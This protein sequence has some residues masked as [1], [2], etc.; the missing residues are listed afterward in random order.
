MEGRGPGGGMVRRWIE[1]KW[2]LKCNIFCII[3]KDAAL[4]FRFSTV[5]VP[6]MRALTFP[7][8]YF[9]LLV[10]QTIQHFT[11]TCT[12]REQAFIDTCIDSHAHTGL[13]AKGTKLNTLIISSLHG[14]NH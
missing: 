10:C 12:H 2:Y 13:P 4:V 7:D 5:R 1:F 3:V 11:Q 9:H 8:K 6:L 14:V